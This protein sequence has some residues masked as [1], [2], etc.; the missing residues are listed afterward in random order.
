MVKFLVSYGADVNETSSTGQTPLHLAVLS[1]NTIVSEF[2]LEKGANLLVHTFVINIQIYC[3]C[4]KQLLLHK[5][6]DSRLFKVLWY[7]F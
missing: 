6:Y 4:M 5:N 2:L 7:L 3:N 1:G